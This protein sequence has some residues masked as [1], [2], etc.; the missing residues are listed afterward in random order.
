MFVFFFP[1]LRL[2]EKTYF[3]LFGRLLPSSLVRIKILEV[4]FKA[5]CN[6]KLIKTLSGHMV[7]LKSLWLNKSAQLQFTGI[8]ERPLVS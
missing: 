3:Y 6:M 5:T 7:T 4:S 1:P 8:R 2:C